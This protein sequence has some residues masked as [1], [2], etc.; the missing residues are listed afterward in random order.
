MY[1]TYVVPQTVSIEAVSPTTAQSIGSSGSGAA[2]GQQLAVFKVTNNGSAAVRLA[3]STTFRFAQSGTTTSTFKVYVG[4]SAAS[5]NTALNST[6]TST[7]ANY[8]RPDISG[9]AAAD[10]TINGGATR[11]LVIKN[12]QAM[13]SGATVQFS[14]DA[15]GD[16]SYQV[17][18]SQLGYSGNAGTGDTDTSDVIQNLPISGMPQT[19]SPSTA[20]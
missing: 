19:V 11:Y 7:Q 15:I 4:D 6:A 20:L 9:A 18:E 3:T 14:A 5:A 2:A 1:F 13:A 16:L 12:E 8:F 10:R 17:D